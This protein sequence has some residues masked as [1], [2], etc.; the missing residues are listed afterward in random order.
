[1]AEE[2]PN[3]KPKGKKGKKLTGGKRVAVFAAVGVGAYL[4]YRWYQNRNASSTSSTATP[5]GSSGA[6]TGSGGGYGTGGGYGGGG[7]GGTT[8]DTT[9][10]TTTTPT[11]TTAPGTGAVVPP[12]FT[13]PGTKI[14]ALKPASTPVGSTPL[15]VDGQNFQTTANFK[16]NTTGTT[17]L[18]ISNPSEAAR[19]NRLGINLVH[20][21]NDP[22]GKGLFV[23]VPA[24]QNPA[25]YGKYSAADNAAAHD[26]AKSGYP[27]TATG[28]KTG[29]GAG[30]TGKGTTAAQRTAAEQKATGRRFGL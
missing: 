28:T 22:T 20:N 17:Y 8:P 9:T 4:L 21:P 25:N 11:T 15:S 10:P 12:S 18:G 30:Y 26:A 16:D 6:P 3:E 19:L 29:S 7:G 14:T 27:T 24:G 1:M 23:P 5:T 13:S 2:T